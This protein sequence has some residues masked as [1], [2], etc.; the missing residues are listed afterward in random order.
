MK[1][2]IYPFFLTLTLAFF[3]LSGCQTFNLFTLDDDRALGLQVSQQI[4]SDPKQFP[5][6]PERGNQ[7][8]YKYVRSLTQKLLNTGKVNYRNEFAWEVKI[9]KDDET[10]NAFA[11]PGGYIYVYT[12]LIKFLDS[13]D[14]LAGVLGHEI[15]HAAMRHST[16][17]LT[18]IYGLSTL[19]NVVTKKAEPGVLEQI[20]LSLV[21][22]SFSR[23][24]ETEADNYSVEY[25][26]PTNLHAAGAAGFFKKIE[27]A[28][29]S[30]PPAFLSTH[31]NPG[32]RVAN[33][34]NKA[35]MMN[36]KGTE[37]NVREYTRI[38]RLL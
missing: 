19:L 1:S 5:I 26:C 36:C 3:T 35:N 21:S 16:R 7:E 37:K 11:T 14:Q 10:L 22:L 6:L 17:Q 24:H 23:A 25:L 30:R 8:V 4:E 34:E 20:A 28:G 27:S 33:I 2:V 13:E 9:I 29:G 12:G 15:A 31:P 32:N 38:K 18:K